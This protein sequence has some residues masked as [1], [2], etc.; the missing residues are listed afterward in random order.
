MVKLYAD[1]YFSIG[2][3]HLTGGKPC[4][5][6]A[7]SGVYE[8][9]AFA[10]VSD[11]CSTGGQTDVGA[12]V[13]ALSTSEAIKRHLAFGKELSV[14]D[15]VA[16]IN[17]WQMAAI[18]GARNILGLEAKDMLATCIYA[19]VT[20]EGGYL[21]IQGDGVVAVKDLWGNIYMSRVEWAEN[22]PFYPAYIEGGL[23]NFISA[24]GGDLSAKRVKK[25]NFRRMNDGREIEIGTEDFSLAEGL[26]GV[27][28][29]FDPPK[30]KDIAFIALFSDGVA[31]IDGMDWKDAV[32]EFMSFKNFAGVFAKRRMIR[33]IKNSQKTSRGPMD[34]IAY[35]VI[36]FD[37]EK[38]A[39]G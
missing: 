1:H 14:T 3:V 25:E 19:C 9:S 24:H 20:P 34:D 21:N 4:Q 18:S 17:M 8:N 30:M 16:K 13:T 36:R 6:Y 39:E 11:G 33:G 2:H 31:Q 26:R 23:D 10:I 22:T 27:S 28:L 35:A 7:L 38:N 5:D 32:Y 12:R 15:A 37:D 29:F